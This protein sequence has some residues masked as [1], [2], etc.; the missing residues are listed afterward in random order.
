MKHLNEDAPLLF[1]EFLGSLIP[2]RW[3]VERLSQAG[4]GR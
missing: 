1:S 4:R 3:D 2:D